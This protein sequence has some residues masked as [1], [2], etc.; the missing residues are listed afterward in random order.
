MNAVLKSLHLEGKEFATASE[1][2][3]YCNTHGLDYYNTIRYLISK[4]Y[5]VRIFKGIFYVKTFDEIKLNKTKYSHYELVAKGLEL[6]G[7]ENWYFGL[8]T[9]LKFNNMTHEHYAVD[10]VINDIIFRNKPITISGYKFRFIKIKK[11]LLGF[12]IIKENHP[13]SDPEKTVLDLIYLWG[14]NGI[15]KEKIIIDTSEFIENINEKRI[16]RYSNSYPKSVQK[17]LEELI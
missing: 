17:I 11:E 14:Y 12:G 7:V 16:M 10:Q 15:P 4:S 1:I 3:Q 8:F 5:L 9:A 2:K 13:Y 6:K